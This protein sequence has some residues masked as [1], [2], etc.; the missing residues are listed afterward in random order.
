MNRGDTAFVDAHISE[1][2]AAYEAQIAH[3]SQFL[4][5]FR[6]S[7]D[8]AEKTRVIGH[9]D[10]VK[11]ISEALDSLENIRA[12]DCAQKIEE[13]MQYRL[14]PDI[15]RKLTEIQG[16]LKLY[17]DEVAEHMLQEMLECACNV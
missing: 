10:F 11:G 6:K 14:D 1:L 13:L 3:I 8:M 16:Q 2:L 15:E 17:E 7:E 9:A 4:E 5:N 12:K